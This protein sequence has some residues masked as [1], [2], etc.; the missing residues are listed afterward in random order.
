MLEEELVQLV[1][2]VASGKY[3][4]QR[5]ELKEAAGG[6]PSKLYDTL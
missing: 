6:T 4:K 2:K 5:I 1:K 3:E